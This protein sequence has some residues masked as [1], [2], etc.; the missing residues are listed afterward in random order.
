MALQST[1]IFRII[2]L[3]DVSDRFHHTEDEFEGEFEG[4][5]ERNFSMMRE[6]PQSNVPP[7]WTRQSRNALS[8]RTE[9]NPGRKCSVVR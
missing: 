6:A 1:N 7:A 4:A 5:N 8:H 2:R 9:F 3:L